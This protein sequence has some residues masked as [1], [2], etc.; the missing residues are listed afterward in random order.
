MQLFPG[1]IGT[2]HVP[3]NPR[4]PAVLSLSALVPRHSAET[5]RN[6]RSFRTKARQMTSRKMRADFAK[7]F[8]NNVLFSD[9]QNRRRKTEKKTDILG[10]ARRDGKA[11]GQPA[12]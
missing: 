11:T 6:D 2:G 1:S 9:L 10:T 8:N 12:P 3:Q 7:M 5:V 4:N